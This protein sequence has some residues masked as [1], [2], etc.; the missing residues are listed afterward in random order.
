[1]SELT[2]QRWAV[3]S[4]RGA[5]ASSLTYGEA[6]LLVRQ[7]AAEGLHGLSIITAAAA[8]RISKRKPAKQSVPDRV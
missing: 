2:E 4:E 5:E 6:R 1:M 7:L 3:V 8:N